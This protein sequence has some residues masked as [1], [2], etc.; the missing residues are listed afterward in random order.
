MQNFDK[1]IYAIILLSSVFCV[2]NIPLRMYITYIQLV[3]VIS[4]DELIYPI[5]FVNKRKD[6]FILE[7]YIHFIFE[8]N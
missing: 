8:L 3:L 1:F 5:E 7:S 6:G 2:S 4:V